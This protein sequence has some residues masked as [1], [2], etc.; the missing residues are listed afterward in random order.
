MSLS[1]KNTSALLCLVQKIMKSVNLHVVIE[2]R[3]IFF[4]NVVEPLET[5]KHLI[6]VA[7][8]RVLLHCA[9]EDCEFCLVQP[10]SVGLVL[11][12]IAGKFDKRKEAL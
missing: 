6:V 10:Y 1:E 7:L 2:F 3:V 11:T 9:K 5:I 8:I 4:E 12:I